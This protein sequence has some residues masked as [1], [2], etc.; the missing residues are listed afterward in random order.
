MSKYTI[1]LANDLGLLYQLDGNIRS[2]RM[3]FR[4][5]S[6]LKMYFKIKL[7]LTF[8]IIFGISAP[9]L[10]EGGGGESGGNQQSPVQVI[11]QI[12][13]TAIILRI[14]SIFRLP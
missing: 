12:A 11:V 13:I 1:V 2:N 4:N 14:L 10:A 7:F 6:F 9:A 3:V 5:L 8:I